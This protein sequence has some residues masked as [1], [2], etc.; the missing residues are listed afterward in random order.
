MTVALVV[1]GFFLAIGFLALWKVSQVV[2][3]I[4]EE[5]RKQA[6]RDAD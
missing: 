6:E 4:D 1:L 3:K 2:G 5:E